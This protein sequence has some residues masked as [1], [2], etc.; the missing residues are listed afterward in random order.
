LPCSGLVIIAAASNL[1]FLANILIYIFRSSTTYTILIY[2]L[3]KTSGK[4][5]DGSTQKLPHFLQNFAQNTYFSHCIPLLCATV[6]QILWTQ[7]TQV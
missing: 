1:I 4:G 2:S 6:T 3:C 5:N 7:C